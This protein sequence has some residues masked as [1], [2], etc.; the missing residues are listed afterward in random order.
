MRRHKVFLICFYINYNKENFP[1]HQW[2]NW[3]KWST[4]H[5]QD[6]CSQKFGQKTSN[7]F[8]PDPQDPPEFFSGSGHVSFELFRSFQCTSSVIVVG[9]LRLLLV[10]PIWSEFLDKLRRG[11]RSFR[12]RRLAALY[13][14]RGSTL[15]IIIGIL[16]TC[17]AE[18]ILGNIKLQLNLLS[19]IENGVVA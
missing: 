19:F 5:H 9:L 8:I 10:S 17:T 1:R 6:E 14:D 2:I 11:L 4:T 12:Q 15:N 3:L 18:R 7:C 16:N 13:R